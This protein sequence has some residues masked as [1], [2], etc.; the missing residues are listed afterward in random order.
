M[1]LS[2]TAT[3]KYYGQFRDAVLRGEIPVNR[4]ISM[5]M[6]RI[7]DLIANPGIYYDDAAVEGF[8]Q[9]CEN[10]L[11]LTD[12]ADFHMLDSFKLWGEQIF[13]WYYFTER[14]VYQPSPDNHGGKYVRKMIKKRLV[15]KQYL[16]VGRGAA[17]S[18]YDSCIQSYFQNVDTSTTQQVTTAPTMK[19]A[20]EVLAPIR[21]AINRARGPLF[22]FLTDGSLQ[23]TTG[24]RANRVKLAST[25][26]GIENFLTGSIIEVRPMTIDKL[27]G[28]RNKVTTIDEW[29][30]GDIREDVVGAAEQGASKLDDYLIVA[31]SSEGTVRNSSGDTIK[32]ELMDILKGEY[33]NPH[34]SIWW[35]KL[36][37]VKEV[38]DP[39]MWLKA[40]PNLGI[41]VKYEVYQLDVE[42]AEKVPAAR[43]DILAKRFGL[44]MEGY[45]Y[46]FTYEETLPHRKKVFWSLPCALGADLSQG[47]DFCAFTFLFPLSNGCFGV[48]TR[49]YITSLTL[50]KLPAAMRVK[51]EEFLKEGSL[52]VLEGTV[53]DM[54]EVYEDL[55]KFIIDSGYDV[56]CFGFD[57]YNAKE[58]VTRWTQDNGEYGLEKVIQGARTE[59]VPLGELKILAEQRMLLFDEDL[60]TFTM[61]NSITIEDTNGNR[62][63]LK[64]RY[65][66]KIDSVSA[67]MDAYVAYKLHK[68]DFE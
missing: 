23:N 59:S 14:S 4:E 16:I 68:D 48:K 41:T 31:T 60:M 24:P 55:D 53:L 38:A 66:Q 47:D 19:Q 6:N 5:E 7:D 50:T 36:D 1:A 21:T 32:M 51:Y 39:S 42:R 17:K 45:T 9:Y 46:F 67:M 28:L 63:L 40:N 33:P 49:C 61:G 13:G 57:P 26:K 62:K 12:G 20:E 65:D 56:R 64:R 27:Q 29:L 34:V 22:Q 30:S 8:I 15:N 10:E 37:D 35:Y 11:T 43:N 3:P 25:K 18:L 2:N 54:V 58:F 44:P 52:I